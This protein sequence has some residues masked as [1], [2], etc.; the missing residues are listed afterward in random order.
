MSKKVLTFSNHHSII[1]NV[2][3]RNKKV[4]WKVNDESFEKPINK[5]IIINKDCGSFS[6]TKWNK[7]VSNR[8]NNELTSLSIYILNWEFDPGSG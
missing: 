3:G 2:P 1:K 4:H 5:L 6:T 8:V 7:N